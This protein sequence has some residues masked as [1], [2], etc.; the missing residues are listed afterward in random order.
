MHLAGNLVSF[1]NTQTAPDVGFILATPS[2]DQRIVQIHT[3]R[4]ALRKLQ[5]S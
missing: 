4:N 3:I 1:P 5:Q 2:Y